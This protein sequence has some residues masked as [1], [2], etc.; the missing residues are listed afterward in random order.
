[1]THGCHEKKTA[2][3]LLCTR[4]PTDFTCL[5]NWRVKVFE[6]RKHRTNDGIRPKPAMFGGDGFYPWNMHVSL[7]AAWVGLKKPQY[8]RCWPIWDRFW[9]CRLNETPHKIKYVHNGTDEA[10]PRYYDRL[11]Y[12]CTA[13]T[14]EIQVRNYLTLVVSM[15]VRGLSKNLDLNLDTCDVVDLLLQHMDTNEVWEHMHTNFY[16]DE[17]VRT[18]TRYDRW[19][20]SV[21]IDR[22]NG[23]WSCYKDAEMGICRG[24]GLEFTF[25]SN[26]KRKFRSKHR[27]V[28]NWYFLVLKI[29]RK[30]SYFMVHSDDSGFEEDEDF[31]EYEER[32][33]NVGW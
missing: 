5:V 15:W 17:P 3:F 7:Q 29:C 31:E 14:N 21:M 22:N 13:W 26:I 1:M 24:T 18:K 28:I 12:H 2:I 33:E 20:F 8:G 25:E 27:K 4:A 30:K 10:P 19:R 16:V 9:N 23:I 6:T 11:Y 32:V